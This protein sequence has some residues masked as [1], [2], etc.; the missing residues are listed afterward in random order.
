[1]TFCK[2]RVNVISSWFLTPTSK[3]NTAYQSILWFWG[4]PKITFGYWKDVIDAH[5][6]EKCAANEESRDEDENVL[7]PSEFWKGRKY[8][9][10]SIFGFSIVD[11][12]GV[13]KI[14]VPICVFFGRMVSF[15]MYFSYPTWDIECHTFQK[16][17]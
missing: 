15:L 3:P 13:L 10:I 5:C 2:S 7:K 14:I 9:K 17:I 6:L 8:W 1:M 12:H 4:Y 11:I 16:C